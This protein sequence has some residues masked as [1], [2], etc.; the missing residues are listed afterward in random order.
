VTAAPETTPVIESA[1]QATVVEE[2]A[3]PLVEEDA[4]R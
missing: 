4:V 2:G 1:P 3:A